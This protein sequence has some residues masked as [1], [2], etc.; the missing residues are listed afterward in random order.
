S[1]ATTNATTERLAPPSRT[2]AVSATYEQRAAR[3]DEYANALATHDQP[4]AAFA[5]DGRLVGFDLFD[6]AD[7]LR[8]LFPKLVRSFALD[9]ID[10][11][12]TNVHVAAQARGAVDDPNT[13]L[14]DDSR[15]RDAIDPHRSMH[16]HAQPTDSASLPAGV[17]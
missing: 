14:H 11:P 9:A 1:R 17:Q 8:R 12:N 10:S 3:L 2:A 15:A 13:N 7:T 5:I 6:A 16:N 4:G